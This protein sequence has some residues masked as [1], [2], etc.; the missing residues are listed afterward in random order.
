MTIIASL[1]GRAITLAATAFLGTGLAAGA[2]GATVLTC[3]T[4]GPGKSGFSL[5]G[6]TQA[7]CYDGN[8]SNQI[9]A[10]FALFGKTGWKLSDKNDDAT[11]GDGT[12]NFGLAP[13]N[14]TRGGFLSIRGASGF[15]DVAITLKAGNS[16]GAFLLDT[17]S[18]F[19]GWASSKG[20]SHASIYYNEGTSGGGTPD[21]PAPIPLPA[22]A[23]LLLAGL[24]GLGAAARRRKA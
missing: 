13:E 3:S 9:D 10:G 12:I 2:A 15:K 14:G 8:D 22:A 1:R 4:S 19:G 20:L 11:S 6:A 5:G 7:E 23:W 16:F 17:A 21:S 18:T 24:G